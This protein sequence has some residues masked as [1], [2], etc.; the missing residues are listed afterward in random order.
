MHPTAPVARSGPWSAKNYDSILF[1]TKSKCTKFYDCEHFLTPVLCYVSPGTTLDPREEMWIISKLLQHM[2]C[3]G[4]W[5][6]TRTWI[7]SPPYVLSWS[8]PCWLCADSY[9]TILPDSLKTARQRSKW[10]RNLICYTLT[11]TCCISVSRRQF[12][13]DFM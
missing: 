7:A 1:C 13:K 11:Q 4:D 5:T 10:P 3:C 8:M 6:H 9:Y 12:I 2:S